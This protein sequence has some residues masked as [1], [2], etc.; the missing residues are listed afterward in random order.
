MAA[1]GCRN[2]VAVWFAASML[3]HLEAE[4]VLSAPRPRLRHDH[5]APGETLIKWP[6][7]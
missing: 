4:P 7:R 6:G 3:D 1:A 5:G 2:G